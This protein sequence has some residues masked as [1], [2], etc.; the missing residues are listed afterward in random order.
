MQV[1]TNTPNRVPAVAT[2]AATE[3]MAADQRTCTDIEV[4]VGTYDNYLFSYRVRQQPDVSDTQH[5]HHTN[6]QLIPKRLQSVTFERLNSQP[7]HAASVRCATTCGRYLATGGSDDRIVVVDLRRHQE[8]QLLTH[9]AGTVNRVAFTPDGSHLFS[10]S[11]DGTLA[12]TKTGSWL[13]DNVWRTPHSG[14]A[15][16]ALAVHPS[17]KLALTVGRDQTLRTW[18]LIKGRQCFTTNLRTL[19]ARGDTVETVVWSPLGGRFALIAV[20]RVLVMSVGSAGVEREFVGAG[21]R[22]TTA[23]CWL[24]EDRLLLGQESGRVRFVEVEEDE[25]DEEEEGDEKSDEVEVQ[26]HETRVKDMAIMHGHL[27]TITW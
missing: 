21:K 11:D 10:A 12:A 3:P 16:T 15:I 27:V 26:V 8:I 24:D 13:T 2:A 14:K 5:T 7:T 9:H 23:L 17:G 22:R 20:D 4:F 19:C 25:D 18:S 1:K 6:P